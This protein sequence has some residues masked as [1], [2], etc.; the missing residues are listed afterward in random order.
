[1]SSVAV[2]QTNQKIYI[3]ADTAIS[4]IYN[5]ERYRISNN[6]KKLYSIKDS[7]IFCS[8]T[9]ELAYK[10]MAVYE[11]SNVYTVE[12]LSIIAKKLYNQESEFITNINLDIMVFCY[13]GNATS[14]YQISP[15]LNFTPDKKVVNHNETGIYSGGIKTQEC[16]EEVHGNLG[17]YKNISD[18]FYNVFDKIKCEEIGGVVDIV[19]VN[20]TGVKVLSSIALDEKNIKKI[21][22]YRQLKEL[23]IAEMVLGKLLLTQKITIGDPNGTWLT[24][25]PK[26]TITDRCGRVAMKFGLYET[27]PDLYGMVINRYEDTPACSTVLKNKVI[28]NSKDGFVI[29][30]ING[31]MNTN[32]AWLDMNGLLNVKKLQIDYADGVLSNGITIDSENGIVTTRSDIMYRSLMSGMRGF[33]IQ[34]NIGSASDPRWKDIFWADLNGTVHAQDLQIANSFITNGGIEGAYIILRDGKGGVMKLYPE[35]GMWAGHEDAENAPVWI[36]PDGTAIFKKLIV[37]NGQTGGLMMDS[38]N[39]LIDLDQWDMIGVG[40]IEADSILINTAIA[41]LGLISNLAVNK[42]IT[43]GQTDTVGATSDYIHIENNEFMFKTGE[44]IGRTQLEGN[45]KKLYWTDSSKTKATTQSTAYPI[46]SLS[47]DGKEKFSI[48]TTNDSNRTPIV[49]FGR[50]DGLSDYSGKAYIKKPN[51]SWEHIYHA[52]TNSAERRVLFKDTGVEVSAA[53]GVVE[54]KHDNGTF[55]RINN[56]GSIE[57]SSN[58]NIHFTGTQYNFN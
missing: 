14:V 38:E 19:E 31:S 40:R 32:V 56:N 29:Q 43:L 24:E 20:S 52:S 26:T 15:Y 12:N 49:Q 3:A 42:L 33:V 2:I 51:G 46:W 13:E 36:K 28:I 41:G 54:I 17:K 45:G 10:I 50:G 18:L 55:I 6:G 39:K 1:M 58:G 8:G 9:M 16:L 35:Y 47:I 11:Q 27:N 22:N 25:G 4:T 44:I 30:Q 57:V 23:V 53:T 48:K 21:S 7:L 5:E 37:R 34:Q